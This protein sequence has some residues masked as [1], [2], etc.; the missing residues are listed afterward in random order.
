V[1]GSIFDVCPLI[2]AYLILCV[3][4]SVMVN[5]VFDRLSE[6]GWRGD[7]ERT[8]ERHI[9]PLQDQAR[10]VVQASR[11]EIVALKNFPGML[12]RNEK[13]LKEME[14]RKGKTGMVGFG[15]GNMPP[16]LDG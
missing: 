16:G 11:F 15:S 14:E 12:T 9:V 8:V 3:P 2:G 6:H 5:T 10:R 1:D 4:T 7:V 13:K